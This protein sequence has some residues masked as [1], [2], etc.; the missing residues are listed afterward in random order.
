V[1]L[2]NQDGATRSM[3]WGRGPSRAERSGVILI[4]MVLIVCI[5]GALIWLDPMALIHGSGSGMP[6]NEERRL[7][8][9]GEEVKQPKEGQ[10]KIL[11]N[12]VFEGQIV[13]DNEVKGGVGLFILTDGRI[14]G[15]WAGKYNP[16][17]DITWEVVG[18]RFKGNIDPTKIYS[19]KDGEDPRKL[20][21]IAKGKS[22]ILETNSKTD[23]IRTATGA[24]YVTGWLD[25]EY[26]AVGKVTITSDKKTYWEYYWQSKGK[27]TMMVPDFGPSLPGLF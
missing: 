3:L 2:D 7:V 24:I 1:V 11:D 19:D 16:E 17:P 21:F 23:K 26:Y 4:L 6:W 10:P 22:L 27:K 20:Y 15:V 25:N 14:K 18:S 9:P 8:R 13:E 5:I 12:L